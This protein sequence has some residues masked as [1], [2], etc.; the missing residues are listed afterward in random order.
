MH[1]D[2]QSLPVAAMIYILHGSHWRGG[3]VSC[4]IINHKL[5]QALLGSFFGIFWAFCVQIIANITSLH[6][7]KVK[8]YDF[9]KF[10][11]IGVYFIIFDNMGSGKLQICL[12]GNSEVLQ[13]FQIIYTPVPHITVGTGI[14]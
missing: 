5:L 8:L 7:K 10:R 2:F 14:S 12:F 9:N 1:V 11:K 13:I 3:G 4:N 6:C